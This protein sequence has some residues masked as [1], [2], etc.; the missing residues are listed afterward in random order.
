MLD[1]DK[2]HLTVTDLKQWAYC[3]RV[4]YY[5]HCVQ[6]VRPR[7]YKMDAGQRAHRDEERKAKRRDF[8]A[9]DLPGGERRFE[10]EL[11][12][13][14]HNLIGKLDELVITPDG[15]H[16]PVDYK[17]TKTVAH[18]HR[19]Q[20]MAYGLLLEETYAVSVPHGY[21]LLIPAR[22]TVKVS[23]TSQLRSTTLGMLITMQGM[24][25]RET[26][27]APPQNRVQCA[28]CEFRRFCNDV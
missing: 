8:S 27:P 4:V 24:L 3:P 16:L 10:V 25:A 22:K 20:L 19:I 18:N 1:S 9:Y 17:L 6:D 15:L 21:I 28:A 14:S 7:T 11:Y 5:E 12:S 13:P 23:F 26:L 2:P